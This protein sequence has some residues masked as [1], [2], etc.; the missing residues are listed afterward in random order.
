MEKL[1]EFTKVLGNTQSVSYIE[2][3]VSFLAYCGLEARKEKVHF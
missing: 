1:E 3:P 2:H